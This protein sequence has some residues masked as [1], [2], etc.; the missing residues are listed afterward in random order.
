MIAIA[1]VQKAF[2]LCEGH[3]VLVGTMGLKLHGFAG[4]EPADID[5]LV[6]EEVGPKNSE[7]SGGSYETV[8]DG[9]RVNYILA[10]EPR[11]PYYDHTPTYIYG[12]PVA[13]ASHIMGLKKFAGRPKDATFL[14]NWEGRQI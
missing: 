9:V 1:T 5:F 8:I 3:G 10:D 7:N 2:G 4:V 14:A 12:V 13:S 11:L 6:L